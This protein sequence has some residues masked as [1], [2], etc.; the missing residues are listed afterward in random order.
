MKGRF[1]L[2][3]FPC[4]ECGHF[5]LVDGMQEQPE[6]SGV[7]VFSVERILDDTTYTDPELRQFERDASL[8]SMGRWALFN[9]VRRLRY[10][11]RLLT[12]AAARTWRARLRRRQHS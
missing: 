3:P 10:K 8:R 9:E 12:N 2:K 4:P 6:A 7:K 5:L 1:K 11:N